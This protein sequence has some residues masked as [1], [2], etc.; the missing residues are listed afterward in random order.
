[1]AGPVGALRARGNAAILIL[2]PLLTAAFLRAGALGGLLTPASGIGS[3]G[4]VVALAINSPTGAALSVVAAS[5]ICAAGGLAI[6]SA[7]HCGRA[8]SSGNAPAAV[9]PAGGFLTAALAVD[10]FDRLLSWPRRTSSS[11]CNAGYGRWR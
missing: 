3:A 1:V 5:L 4:T 11:R 7:H 6:T 9:V 2:D 8:C 10:R